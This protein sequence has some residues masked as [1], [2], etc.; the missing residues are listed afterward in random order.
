M[1]GPRSGRRPKPA[2]LR[3]ITG[4]RARPH[5]RREPKAATGIPAPPSHLTAGE[6][7]LWDYYCPLLASAKVLTLQ[8]RDT[9]A[10]FVEARDQVSQ[11]KALQSDADYRRVLV[12]TVIDGAGNERVRVETNPLDVQRR[13]WTDKARLCAA[14]LGLSPMSRARVSTVGGE[15]AEADPIETLMRAVK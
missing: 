10:Q 7:E 8:D 14:E 13:A 1:G 15:D 12:S 4:S 9:L 11:I 6:R 5:H 2:A 3:A